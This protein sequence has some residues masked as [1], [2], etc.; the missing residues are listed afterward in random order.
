MGTGSRSVIA[1]VVAVAVVSASCGGG[2]DERTVTY[3]ADSLEVAEADV[4]YTTTEGVQRET[5]ALPW[6]LTFAVDDEFDGD[7]VVTNPTSEGSVECT[8]EPPGFRP[9]VA[10][11]E[12]SATCGGSFTID[13]S[14]ASAD[15][16]SDRV[17]RDDVP[18]P[19]GDAPV[20]TSVRLTGGSGAD[21][22]FAPF[23]PVTIE[24]ELGSLPDEVVID[25]EADTAPPGPGDSKSLEAGQLLRRGSAFD[26]DE[27]TV[28]EDITAPGEGWIEGDHSVVVEVDLRSSDDEFE[29]VEESFDLDFTVV[30]PEVS[31]VAFEASDGRFRIDHPSDWGVDEEPASS[32]YVSNFDLGPPAPFDTAAQS[33]ATI[34]TVS[35]LDDSV[36]VVVRVLLEEAR[37]TAPTFDEWVD[38]RLGA[39]VDSGVEVTTESEVDLDHGSGVR[40]EGTFDDELTTS[41]FTQSADRFYI[42]QFVAKDIVDE[43]T[44]ATGLA[45]LDNVVFV[46]EAEPPPTAL[47]ESRIA[48]FSVPGPGGVEVANGQMSLPA[49]W[50]VADELTE[51]A[52]NRFL[53]RS[54]APDREDELE[55]VQGYLYLEVI[56]PPPTTADYSRFWIDRSAEQFASAGYELLDQFEYSLNLEEEPG[57]R[58]VWTAAGEVVDEA[59]VVSG[60]VGITV[61]LEFV[62]GTYD[63]MLFEEIA[64]QVVVLPTE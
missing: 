6:S 54:N 40:I 37:F 25:V 49:T 36:P 8:Y 7:L 3:A 32:T 22:S 45:V 62:D 29:P 57:V 47:A 16:Y 1:A 58:A 17:D 41:V 52:P 59:F 18:G 55:P 35:P 43:G 46:P 15:L 50:T 9:V 19:D 34:A 27:H 13:G 39:L 31:T 14:T 21:G 56:D 44:I 2:D 26:G 4:E 12:V 23:D 5:V 48:S 10:F 42:L 51:E 63:P 30:T 38:I 33:L 60:N 20:V 11:G 28:T 53:L 24:I 61:R 64:A